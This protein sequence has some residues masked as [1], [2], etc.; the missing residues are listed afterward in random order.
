MAEST[1]S[2]PVLYD[3][4][5]HVAW[6]TLSTPHNHNA[7]S[8]ALCTALD[9]AVAQALADAE[10]RALVL[11][12][13]GKTFCAGADLKSGGGGAAR[14]GEAASHP[15]RAP[16]VRSIARLW[17]APKPVVGRIQGNAWGG[18]LGL[19]A[20]CD[21]GIAVDS[22][23]YAFTEVRLGLMPAIIS[24]FV[25]RKMSLAEASPFFLTGERFTADQAK[26]MHLLHEVV[27]EAELDAAVERILDS[28]RQGGPV[29]LQECK[30]LLRRIPLLS[31]EAG[32]DFA[33]RRIGE[34]FAS[35]EGREGMAAFAAKRKP[36]WVP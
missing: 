31:V 2:A 16:F 35:P 6:I 23:R 26:A 9:D 8:L 28:L 12:G 1:Q 29:A 24:V 3:V 22:G 32:L 18:G 36:S 19:M 7:L 14:Q 25:L 17:N 34:L 27:P 21:I 20:A 30:Q 11:T 5:N 10:V 13:V 15:E 4:R 33:E